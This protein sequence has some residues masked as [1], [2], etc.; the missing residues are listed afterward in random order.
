MSSR[1]RLA[2]V[3]ATLAMLACAA[4]FV[5]P[6]SE[7]RPPAAGI[8]SMTPITEVYTYGQ[9]VSAVAIEYA[10]PVDARRLDTTT[11]RVSDSIYNFRFNPIEDLAKLEDRTITDVYTNSSPAVRRDGHSVP[12]R[13]VIV[14]LDPADKGGWT[15]IVSKCPTFLCTV[16]VNPDLLT[17]VVQQTDVYAASQGKGK[18]IARAAP[19]TSRKVTEKP[20]NLLVDEFKYASFL[21]NGMVLPYHYRLPRNYDPARR[22]PLVV[23]LPG[24]GMGW[25]GDNLGVQLAADIPAT[26]WMQAKWT[27]RD[28]D[29]I[30]LAPQNQR[31][32]AAAEGDLLLALLDRFTQ[33]FSVERSRVYATSVSYGSTL[34]WHAFAKRPELFAGGLVTGGFQI[35]DVQAKAIAAAEVPLWITHGI[36]DHLLNISLA[37]GT[38]T[39]LSSAYEARGKSPEEIARLVHYTEYDNAAYSLPDYHAAF[40]P[41]YEDPTILEWLLDQRKPV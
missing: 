16:K 27:H 34:L 18:V 41:T 14:T 38:N 6:Q 17:R 2:A 32:G 7:A 19:G 15:V 21:Q 3:P 33:D 36:N 4:A 20:V 39:A 5:L 24:H 9:K 1:R 12:G 11:F 8:L 40:G 28:E 25:D 26:A 35:S 13:Y 22:Y 10:E 37:R 23:V 30:I 29:V 31:V